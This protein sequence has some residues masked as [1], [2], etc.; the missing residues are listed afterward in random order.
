MAVI[1][2]SS[3]SRVVGWEGK[4]F[5]ESRN[6]SCTR[7]TPRSAVLRLEKKAPCLWYLLNQTT[8]PQRCE[9]EQVH[10]FPGGPGRSTT[11]SP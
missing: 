4:V 9:D 10:S 3:P 7:D 6:L 5:T 2:K 1:M 11:A 8:G